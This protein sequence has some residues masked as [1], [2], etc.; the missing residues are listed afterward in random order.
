MDLRISIFSQY[1]LNSLDI[2]NENLTYY[3]KTD[4]NISSNFKKFSKTWWKRRRQAHEFFQKFT[5]DN[6]LNFNKNLDFFITKII[7]RFLQ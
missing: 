2:I 4:N 3:R 1:I 6:E 5:Q 7:C